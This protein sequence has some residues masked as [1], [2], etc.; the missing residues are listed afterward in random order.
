M[1]QAAPC[2]MVRRFTVWDLEAPCTFLPSAPSDV[3]SLPFTWEVVMVIFLSSASTFET[4]RFTTGG[5]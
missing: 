1:D 3:G 4:D 2:T 5:V